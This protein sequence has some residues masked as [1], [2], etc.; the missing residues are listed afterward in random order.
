[1]VLTT[2]DASTRVKANATCDTIRAY[3]PLASQ[4]RRDKNIEKNAKVYP[5][6]LVRN[7]FRGKTQKQCAP[8]ATLRCLEHSVLAQ[9][10]HWDA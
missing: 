3:K 8:S 9:R 6:N 10:T 1:M 7:V 4:P 5:W 2:T